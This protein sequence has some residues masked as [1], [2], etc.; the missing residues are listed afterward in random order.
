M[1]VPKFQVCDIIVTHLWEY[2][3]IEKVEEHILVGK[4]EVVY[5]YYVIMFKHEPNKSIFFYESA[6]TKISE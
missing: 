3:I 1:I 6:L 2:G 5:V 4:D